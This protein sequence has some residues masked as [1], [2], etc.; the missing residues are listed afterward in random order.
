MR[1]IF[2]SR[3]RKKR[4]PPSVTS[5]RRLATYP[6][7]YPSG[8]YRVADSD[9]LRRGEVRLLKCL[10]REVVLW[11]CQSSDHVNVT[12]AFCPHLGFN[13]SLGNVVGECIECAFHGWRIAGSGRAVSAPDG[14]SASAH[15]R[16]ESFPTREV[17]GQILVFFDSRRAQQCAR[18]EPPYPAHRIAEVDSGQFVHR[19]SYN[20]GRVHMHIIEF[21]EN[22]VDNA[23][24]QPIHGRMR[25]P[26]TQ[27][28]V[29]GVRIDHSA[30][31]ERDPDRSWICYFLNAPTISILGRRIKGAD[32]NARV[33]FYGPASLVYFRFSVPR[34]GEIE[35]IQ[36]HLPI[37]PLEQQVD[38]RWYADRKIPRLLVSYVVG[39]W[40]SQWRRDIRI[41]ENKIYRAKP[42][43]AASDGPVFSARRWYRQFLPDPR[44][45]LP[46]PDETSPRF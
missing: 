16:V 3:L 19:G 8:W 10:G 17:Q 9:S 22:S 21:A 36:S 18:D 14:D 6:Y 20:A 39:N 42:A 37:R 12:S 25:V 23:H 2:P 41:W 38:F 1:G 4:R 15:A 43:L 30:G 46:I 32:A 7:P 29:P 34:M 31:W 28:P 44:D 24:F 45:A 13:L 40:I 26:W 27:I 11:R 35:M 5:E 33:M